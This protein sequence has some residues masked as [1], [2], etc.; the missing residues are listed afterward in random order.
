MVHQYWTV[1]IENTD[2]VAESS[3]RLLEN[4]VLEYS[5]PVFTSP[6]WFLPNSLI[7]TAFLDL[8]PLPK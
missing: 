3:I 4:S 2:I 8:N 5:S 6:P 7:F 1:Q